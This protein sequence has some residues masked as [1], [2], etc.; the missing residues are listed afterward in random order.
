MNKN[1]SHQL[2]RVGKHEIWEG[3][4]CPSVR[5]T[6]GLFSL[7]AVESEVNNGGFFPILL[8][9]SA[10]SASFVVEALETIGA[11]KR[12]YRASVL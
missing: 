4:L 3:R 9:S 8:S 5:T 12:G 6:E 1:A 7:W 11:Q 2:V 10:E